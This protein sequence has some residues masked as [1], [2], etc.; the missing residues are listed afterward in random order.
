MVDEGRLNALLHR[1]ATEVAHIRRLL[2]GFG[3][4]IAD[5]EVALPA[6]K[7]RLIVAIEAAADAAS[8]VIA[9]EGLRP[10][11][12]YADTFTSLHEG[13]WLDEELAA[14]LADA[15]KFR[16]VLVHLYEDVDDDRVVEIARTRLTDLEA[17]V[18]AVAAQVRTD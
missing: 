10:P 5:D 3:E 8:H 17:F 18:Q 15:A 13:G 14:L 7:Y 2:D 6:C 4:E 12:S 11:T 9:S 1:V 16:N